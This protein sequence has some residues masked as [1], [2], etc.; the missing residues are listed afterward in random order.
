MSFI[1]FYI[2]VKFIYC[3]TGYSNSNNDNYSDNE[4]GFDLE[5]QEGLIMLG[6]LK[7]LGTFL[8]GWLGWHVAEDSV[9]I[10]Q[11]FTV[12]YLQL[13]ALYNLLIIDLKSFHSKP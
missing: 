1:L 13:Q 4:D 6:G 7:L 3:F 11:Y 12:H 2:S 8:L 10:C 9:S 5:G